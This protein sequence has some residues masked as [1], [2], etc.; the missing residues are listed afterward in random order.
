MKSL[1]GFTALALGSIASLVMVACTFPEH[2]PSY[3]LDDEWIAREGDTYSYVRRSMEGSLLARYLRFSGFSGKHSIWSIELTADA[4]ISIETII[5][6]DMK[7]RFK[8]CIIL[9]DKAV[10]I[11][12]A[13]PGRC[14]QTII[15]PSGK[16]YLALVGDN[17]GG[18]VSIRLGCDL[19]SFPASIKD[20]R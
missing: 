13:E 14:L 2:Y 12:A 20:I 16:S 7:G 3:F 6:K 1:T 11:L 4:G 5:G 19:A 18:I 10:T 15:L 9:P 8:I 17:A